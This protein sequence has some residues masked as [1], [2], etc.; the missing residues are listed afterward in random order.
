MKEKIKNLTILE[1]TVRSE[2]GKILKRVQD[3]RHA[4]TL[5]EVLITL[6]IIGVV[7][8]MTMPTLIAK[9][10]RNILNNQF[11]KTYSVFATAVQK[12]NYD[13]DFFIDCYYGAGQNDPGNFSGCREFFYNHLPKNLSVA[14]ICETKA[15]ENGCM[16]DYAWGSSSS[17]CSQFGSDIIKNNGAI[18]LNDGSIFFMYGDGSAVVAFDVNGKKGPNEPGFDVYSFNLLKSSKNNLVY[19]SFKGTNNLTGEVT[20][21][22]CLPVKKEGAVTKYVDIMK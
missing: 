1:K 5:A 20:I 21:T 12:T 9:I 17:G 22:G 14:K 11:K 8:A 16:P 2:N 13:M 18:V 10:Q 4:F 6:G 15:F 3:D 7:A 19:V